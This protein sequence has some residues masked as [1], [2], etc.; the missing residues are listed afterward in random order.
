MNKSIV[1]WIAEILAIIIMIVVAFIFRKQPTYEVQA[2]IVP[3]VLA[4]IVAGVAGLAGAGINGLINRAQWNKQ[5]EYNSPEAQMDRYRQAGLN[6]NLIYGNGVSSAG[7][8]G[9]MAEFRAQPV[10]TSDLLAAANAISTI[11]ATESNAR[12]AEAEAIAQELDNTAKSIHLQYYGTSLDLQNRLAQARMDY[13]TGQTSLQQ[14]QQAVLVAQADNIIENTKF[15]KQ[16]RE[17]FQPQIIAIR[18][19]QVANDT[20]RTKASIYDTYAHT[21]L[22]REETQN[23]RKDNQYYEE[24]RELRRRIGALGAAGG[25]LGSLAGFGKAFRK[26]KTGSK[27]SSQFSDYYSY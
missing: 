8:A 18:R 19:Q 25:I 1:E 12:K 16:N 20:A 10:G 14:Y 5:N 24:D 2:A 21:D 9:S 26:T 7:N 22:L 3:A 6:P 13:I 27:S 4:A 17:V 15:T 11:K 23:L